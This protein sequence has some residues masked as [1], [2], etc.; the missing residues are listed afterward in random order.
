MPS[1]GKMAE[2][3]NTFSNDA[4]FGT[5]THAIDIHRKSCSYLSISV[6]TDTEILNSF[7]INRIGKGY[8]QNLHPY[9]VPY[10][11]PIYLMAIGGSN[12]TNLIIAC[13]RHMVSTGCISEEC[14]S[15]LHSYEVEMR[16][17]RFYTLYSVGK[18]LKL[19]SKP[20]LYDIKFS[21]EFSGN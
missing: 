13:E 4:F 18:I 3:V 19:F 14:A 15:L 8:M 17:L 21:W 2:N 7:Y 9:M 5:K 11:M 12:Y 6:F 20:N 1:C 16:T 10:L